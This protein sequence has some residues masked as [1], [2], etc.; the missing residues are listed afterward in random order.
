[1]ERP[2][3]KAHEGGARND[4]AQLVHGEK[5]DEY[6]CNACHDDDAANGRP[7]SA[8]TSPSSHGPERSRFRAKGAGAPSRSMAAPPRKPR[9]PHVPRHVPTSILEVH[10]TFHAALRGDTF[11]ISL[12]C[13]SAFR[14]SGLFVIAP[15]GS[16]EIYE[17]TTSIF[18]GEWKRDC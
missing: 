17:L 3:E 5:E 6:E 13:H 1:M 4:G 9:K 18:Y 7:C 11:G 16:T 8:A 14:D 2:Q 15:S 12:R 10:N